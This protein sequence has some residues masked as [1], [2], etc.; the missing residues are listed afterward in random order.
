M[1]GWNLPPGC[2]PGDIERL[3][4]DHPCECCQ[5]DADDCICPICPECGMAG[6]PACYKEDGH[7]MKYNKRQRRNQEIRRIE[8]LKQQIEDGEMY[9]AWLEGQ[10]EDWRDE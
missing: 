7:G 9:L 6:D 3:S 4:Q 1:T 8:D 2:T 10:P 5:N